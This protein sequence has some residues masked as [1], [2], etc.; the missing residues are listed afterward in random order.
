MARY[1]NKITDHG[2][3]KECH[4][5][6]SIYAG[7]PFATRT[8]VLSNPAFKLRDNDLTVLKDQLCQGKCFEELE[9]LKEHVHSPKWVPGVVVAT[10]GE[11]FKPPLSK[12]RRKYHLG[13]EE[14][15]SSFMSILTL[16]NM[17]ET[18]FNVLE[19]ILISVAM[20]SADMFVSIAVFAAPLQCPSSGYQ[21]RKCDVCQEF[22][23]LLTATE[24]SC[25]SGRD[26]QVAPLLCQASPGQE[27]CIYRSQNW[28]VANKD[29]TQQQSLG[30]IDAPC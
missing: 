2:H 10:H 3:T 13:F 19:G 24:T 22:I 1:T 25:T 20:Q 29:W 8:H 27:V 14:S 28:I 21:L 7:N 12:E 18:L 6:Y 26:Q 17:L 30:N 11:N 5:F 15:G 9:I 23:E 16:S 4:G